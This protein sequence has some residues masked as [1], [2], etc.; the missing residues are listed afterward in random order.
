MFWFCI[1]ELYLFV[2]TLRIH[3]AVTR[4]T[5]HR[6]HHVFETWTFARPRG[7]FLLFSRMRLS[8]DSIEPRNELAANTWIVEWLY[9]R[10]ISSTGTIARRNAAVHSGRFRILTSIFVIENYVLEPLSGLSCPLVGVAFVFCGYHACA[11]RIKKVIRIQATWCMGRT[12]LKW[13]NFR[14]SWRWWGVQ[15]S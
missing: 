7:I 3:P 13:C 4:L 2:T 11:L 8:F 15:A 12:F 5:V 9:R 10:I 1:F 6:R 14:E